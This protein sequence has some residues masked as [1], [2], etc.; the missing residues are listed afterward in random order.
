MGDL[1]RTTGAAAGSGPDLDAAYRKMDN[2]E[3]GSVVVESQSPSQVESL[4]EGTKKSSLDEFPIR[5]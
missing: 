2:A 5:I 1:L 4:P 3:S